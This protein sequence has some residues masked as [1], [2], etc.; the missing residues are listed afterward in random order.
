[1]FFLSFPFVN[2]METMI[3]MRSLNWAVHAHGSRTIIKWG[4]QQNVSVSTWNRV[5]ERQ[6]LFFLGFRCFIWA[7]DS[8]TANCGNFSLL[9]IQFMHQHFVRVLIR[10]S[11]KFHSWLLHLIYK[12][13][14]A[15]LLALWIFFLC[16]C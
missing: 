8:A 1:M 2:P 14:T 16:I 6:H 11:N 7:L 5:K 9:P 4:E 15:H 12:H 13:Y 3:K 10:D